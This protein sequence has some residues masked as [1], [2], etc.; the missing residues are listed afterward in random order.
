M[1]Y[2]TEYSPLVDKVQG[3]SNLVPGN[4]VEVV[5][6]FGSVDQTFNC[7]N[8]KLYIPKV[9]FVGLFLYIFPQ[10][11]LGMFSFWTWTPLEVKGFNKKRFSV[12]I[13]L[14]QWD[15]CDLL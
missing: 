4:E 6:A 14:S 11:I 13:R 8:S 10:L 5:L 1:A 3:S 12:K 2:S 15:S 9:F 7:D